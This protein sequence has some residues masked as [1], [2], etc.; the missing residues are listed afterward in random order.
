MKKH[1]NLQK[2]PLPSAKTMNIFQLIKNCQGKLLHN[3]GM[4][5]IGMIPLGNISCSLNNIIFKI[6]FWL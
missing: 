5:P 3:D 1:C 6:M 2:Q 4:I